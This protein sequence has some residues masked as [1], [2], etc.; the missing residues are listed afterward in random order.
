MYCPVCATE[1][2]TDQKF[3]RH[4]GADLQIVLQALNGKTRPLQPEDEIK[5]RK[6]KLFRK[7]GLMAWWGFMT[8][9]TFS[10]IGVAMN[11]ID[12]NLGNVF[13]LLSAIG[14]PIFLMGV[15][16]MIYAKFFLKVPDEQKATTSLHEPPIVASLPG[17]VLSVTE[18]TTELLETSSA[19][20]R[21]R[22]TAPQN[23]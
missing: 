9:F 8:A 5:E 22:D 10:I 14:N 15:V 6:K 20:M 16:M 2:S 23:N 4:C 21:R 12:G 17:P 11:N 1:S 13:M 7:G 3:C 19:R 18:N